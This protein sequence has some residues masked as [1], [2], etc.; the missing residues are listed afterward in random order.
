MTG[1]A[2]SRDQFESVLFEHVLPVYGGHPYGELSRKNG[3]DARHSLYLELMGRAGILESGKSAVDLGG[4]ISWLALMLKEL[5]LQVTMIDDFRGGGGVNSDARATELLIEQFRSRGLAVHEQDLLSVDLPLA[6][7]SVDAVLS[8]HSLEHWHHSPRRLFRE[9]QRVLKDGGFF[10]LGAPNAVNLRKRLS[11]LVGGTN[12]TPLREWYLA[13]D[14]E[15]RGH[16]REPV[17]RELQQLLEWNGFE[18]TDTIGRNF[19]G[20]DSLGHKGRLGAFASHILSLMDPLLRLAPGLCSD[21][22]VVGRRRR[23]AR[24]G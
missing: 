20:L 15:Y 13:G 21:I 3:L 11:V 17:V 16:V 22:H 19:L 18:V 2:F 23:A 12:H 10:L 1:T 6:D 24:S 5:G 14:P 4:G 9:I 7:A 8:L